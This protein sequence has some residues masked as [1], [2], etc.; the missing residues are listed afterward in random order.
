MRLRAVEAQAR[1]QGIR[2]SGE[3]ERIRPA[4]RFEVSFEFDLSASMV[5]T[6]IA[7]PF[8]AAM[9]M[10]SMQS[11]EPLEI[12]P[13]VSPRLS[14]NLPR[15]WDIFHTWWPHLARIPIRAEPRPIHARHGPDCGAT[16]FSG[17]VDSFYSLLKHRCGAGTL[18]VPLSHVIFMRG[19][20]NKLEW[21][22]GVGETEILGIGDCQGG[23]C[24]LHHWR[25]QHTHEPARSRGV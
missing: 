25:N 10:P 2:L 7:D 22:R 3:V 11:G 12:I 17:G 23:G 21:G 1:G 9:L 5:M 24:V 8:A 6:A 18:P 13:P 19:V 15:I 4:D 16:F 20:E 14:F